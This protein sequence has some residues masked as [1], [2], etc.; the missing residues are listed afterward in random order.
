VAVNQQ[1]SLSTFTIEIDR[2]PVLVLQAKWQREAE[3]ICQEWL[4]TNLTALKSGGEPLFDVKS[5]ARVRLA[6][7]DER[8]RYWEASETSK[9]PDDIKVVYLVELDGKPS[10]GF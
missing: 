8:A 9:S 3:E 4:Q 2:R 5:E 1:P 10:A 6:H 7:P